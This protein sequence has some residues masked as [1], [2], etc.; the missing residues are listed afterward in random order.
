VA[1]AAMACHHI[2]FRGEDEL[3]RTAGAHGFVHSGRWGEE[4]WKIKR[5]EPVWWYLLYYAIWWEGKIG[6]QKLDA[7][8]F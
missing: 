8:V 6:K 1:T 4:G 3:E 7:N 5:I 2:A